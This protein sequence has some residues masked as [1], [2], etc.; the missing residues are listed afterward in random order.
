MT[1]HWRRLARLSDARAGKIHAMTS[2][3]TLSRD[4]AEFADPNRI[5]VPASDPGIAGWIR[6]V[7]SEQPRKYFDKHRISSLKRHLSVSLT[8]GSL[9]LFRFD[10]G[11]G[12]V[13]QH[14]PPEYAHR[15]M[16]EIYQGLQAFRPKDKHKSYYA[17]AGWSFEQ[18]SRS[19]EF[20]E[21]GR[22]IID[23]CDE[24]EGYFYL[25]GIMRQTRGKDIQ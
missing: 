11:V 14:I 20:V 9:Q 22:Q 24:Y 19:D 5:A 8:Q 3:C 4:A 2:K 21:R 6:G 16:S 1:G 10:R 25:D 23:H 15:A 13:V 17:L 7:I 12:F 18:T